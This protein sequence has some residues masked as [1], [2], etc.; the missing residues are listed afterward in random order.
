MLLTCFRVV[1]LEI[2]IMFIDV[3][4]VRVVDF[5][6]V[7]TRSYCCCLDMLQVNWTS[8]LLI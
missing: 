8:C 3:S 1:G 6:H 7:K 2:V 5:R 4:W